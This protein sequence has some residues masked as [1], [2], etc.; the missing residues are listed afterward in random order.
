MMKSILKTAACILATA[1]IS[2]T[3]GHGT[4]AINRVVAAPALSP[5]NYTVPTNTT[6]ASGGFDFDL[7]AATASSGSNSSSLLG[8]KS[9]SYAVN[10]TN[11]SNNSGNSSSPAVPSDTS[12]KAVNS[13]GAAASSSSSKA[14]A[15]STTTKPSATT[16]STATAKSSTNNTNSAASAKSSEKNTNSDAPVRTFELI[17]AYDIAKNDTPYNISADKQAIIAYGESRG[18]HYNPDLRPENTSWRGRSDLLID[19]GSD[20]DIIEGCK[21]DIDGMIRVGYAGA[22]F[23]PYFEK[24]S[25]KINDYYSYVLYR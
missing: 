2:V 16:S 22:N 17:S 15:A 8:L 18:L 11:S 19:V 13:S 10:S 12:E 23:N 1:V 9:S 4:A 20:T 25:D 21:S 14:T 3:V 5:D 7:S 6:I 24:K